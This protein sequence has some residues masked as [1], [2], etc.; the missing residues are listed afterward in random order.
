MLVDWNPDLKGV[1]SVLAIDLVQVEPIVHALLYS[2]YVLKVAN[3]EPVVE[4]SLDPSLVVQEIES[5]LTAE[6]LGYKKISLPLKVVDDIV[7]HLLQ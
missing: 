3:F 4:H 2:G 1:V 7:I 5:N 6:E